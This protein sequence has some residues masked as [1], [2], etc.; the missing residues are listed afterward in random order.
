MERWN[1]EGFVERTSRDFGEL[2][3]SVRDRVMLVF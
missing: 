2:V 1:N 3:L